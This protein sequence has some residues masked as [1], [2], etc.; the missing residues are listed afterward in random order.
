MDGWVK[1]MSHTHT[2]T[3]TQMEYYSA[4][5]NKISPFVKI[6][7][8]PEDTVRARQILYDLTNIWILKKQKTNS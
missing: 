8:N 1:E 4:I 6:W 5:R 3:L 7:M 2:H